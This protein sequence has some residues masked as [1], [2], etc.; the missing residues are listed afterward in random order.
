LN[1]LVIGGGGREHALAWRLAREKSINKV[2]CAPGNSGIE[3]DAECCP[4]DTKDVRAAARIAGTVRAD[5]TIV[6]PEA[7]LVAGVADEFA[8][9]GLRILGPVRAAAQ[10]EGSKIFAKKFMERHQIPTAST[11]GIFSSALDVY[12]ELC[13]VDWPLVIK[14]DGLCAGKGVLVTSSPDEATAFVDRVMGRLEFGDAGRHL[15]LEEGLSGEELSYIILTDGKDF[16]PMCPTRDYKRALD[17]DQ[18]PNTGGMG[19]YSSDDILPKQLENQIIDS[20]VRPTLRGLAT[21]GIPYSG[22]L[23]F[24]L[25]ITAEGP[26]VL[27]FNCRL[28]D[29]ETEVIVMRADFDLAQ[30]FM[31]ATTGQLKN[32]SP[33]WSPGPAVC[34]VMA[35]EGY[36][37]NP[38]LNR[39]IRGLSEVGKTSQG[40]VGFHAGTK[41]IDGNYYT[42]GGRVLMVSAKADTLPGARDLAYEA[43]RAIS[44]DG[45]HYRRDIAAE[46]KSSAAT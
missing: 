39:Q 20:V 31:S 28:G 34:V 11:Y 26:K 7:P 30:A 42:S 25:M 45:A 33:K 21:D 27:E 8:S 43:V 29:P 5:L 36:P 3:A 13:G 2:Y 37:G 22:F 35:S 4:L 15:I 19:A 6:G 46:R 9:R 32:V 41:R 38:I 40:A 1:I 18:G 10:L 12:S 23:Y 44:F 16:I 24:G 17:G 14:A